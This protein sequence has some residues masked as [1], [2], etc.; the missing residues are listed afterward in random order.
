MKTIKL[1]SIA[2]VA[3]T[4]ASCSKEAP[5]NITTEK[6]QSVLTA[7]LSQPEDENG[8]KTT[9]NDSLYVVWSDND[10]IAVFANN[11]TEFKKYTS[12][13]TGTGTTLGQFTGDAVTA[14]YAY[15]PY[16]GVTSVD[17]SNNLSVVIP[18]VQTYSANSFGQFDMPML[19]TVSGG[20]LSFRNLMAVLKLQ[21]TGTGIV[22]R[23]IVMSDT[24]K[25]SGMATVATNGTITFS[26]IDGES[27]KWVELD[28]GTTGVDLSTN[29]SFYISVPAGSYA[30]T[31]RIV[32]KSSTVAP[33]KSVTSAKTFTANIIKP[34]ASYSV[35]FGSDFK[36]V[37]GA[38][39]GDPIA[40][41]IDA[42]EYKW[43]PVN[44]GYDG[45]FAV[46]KLGRLF[47]YG[48]KYGQ[49]CFANVITPSEEVRTFDDGSDIFY[50]NKFYSVLSA[51]NLSWAMGVQSYYDS[52]KTQYDPCPV[53]WRVPSK[54][55]FEKLLGIS[56]TSTGINYDGRH[57]G[58]TTKYQSISD[59]GDIFDGYWYNGNDD[60]ANDGVF[61]SSCGMRR[62]EGNHT[63]GLIYR[64][65]IP[66]TTS[67]AP[68]IN[69]SSSVYVQT[70]RSYKDVVSYQ[71]QYMAMGAGIRCIKE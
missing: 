24:Q 70:P 13:N 22:D 12:D 5:E 26:N 52:G 34:M 68:I 29:P 32:S 49:F 41:T 18:R 9:L 48:R 10:A 6:T 66:F 17:G 14:A 21:L 47:Q 25:M 11:A 65:N 56:F 27:Y 35:A 63:E 51:Q 53:G 50:E 57:F 39:V 67:S 30:F 16:K 54:A 55:E 42:T 4:I 19:A 33:D 37:D 61:L 43:A 62:K 1:F 59:G 44:C 7:K 28:C 15:Y 20:R 60:N 8:T 31:I 69:G 38:Y 2:L 23:I 71:I 45:S 36:Y 58:L 40:L 3:V 64:V 46:G